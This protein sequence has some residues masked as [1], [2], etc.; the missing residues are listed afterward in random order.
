MAETKKRYVVAKGA[1]FV[2]DKKVYKEGDVIDESAFKSKE[3]FN[4]LLTSKPPKI[5]EAPPE[6]EKK[7]EN[8]GSENKLG[9]K[10]L[11]ELA[12]KDNFK[13]PE[14]IK[15][16]KDEELKKLLQDAGKLK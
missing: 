11:E 5:V 16:L 4:K 13:K 2:G 3:R 15:N 7:D 9:R 8:S 6:E 10:A 14:E 1:S 12:L